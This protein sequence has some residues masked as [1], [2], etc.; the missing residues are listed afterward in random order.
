MSGATIRDQRSATPPNHASVAGS[1]SRTIRTCGRGGV[2]DRLLATG[3]Q[4]GT[5]DALVFVAPLTRTA[6]GSPPG[7]RLR[8]EVGGGIL[9]LVRRSG[10][11]PRGFG[12][13]PR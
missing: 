13:T 3:W 1:L 7:V 10:P 5:L 11:R 8:C 2:G 9:P 4:G 12:R 6:R